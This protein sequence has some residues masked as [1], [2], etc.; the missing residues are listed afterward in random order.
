MK[1]RP[2][3]LPKQAVQGFQSQITVTNISKVFP[4]S[5]AS[6]IRRQQGRVPTRGILNTDEAGT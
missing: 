5:T 3:V 6:I 4:P 1:T 2:L